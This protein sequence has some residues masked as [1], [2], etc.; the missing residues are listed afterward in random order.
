MSVEMLR[1]LTPLMRAVAPIAAAAGRDDGDGTGD[2]G[3]RR[4][5]GVGADV[6][7][8]CVTCVC[9]LCCWGQGWPGGSWRV[10]IGTVGLEGSQRGQV[11]ISLQGKLDCMWRMLWVC[12]KPEPNDVD[13][14]GMN[15]LW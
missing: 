11:W 7:C 1:P 10:S 3:T 13:D 9:V 14:N 8:I 12:A 2:P 15:G 4:R 5:G 6:I